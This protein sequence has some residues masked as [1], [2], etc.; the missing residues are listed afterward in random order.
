MSDLMGSNQAQAVAQP[1][2]SLDRAC[3]PFV[4]WIK[5]EE[6]VVLPRVD[7]PSDLLWVPWVWLPDEGKVRPGLVRLY[8]DKSRIGF[9]PELHGLKK[10]APSLGDRHRAVFL[11]YSVGEFFRFHR[12]NASRLMPTIRQAIFCV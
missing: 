4:A 6:P 10:A 8:E 5:G 9:R 2:E 12:V 7:A 11:N 1:K 3:C